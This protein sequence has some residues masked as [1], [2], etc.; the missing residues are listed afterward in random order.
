[1][2]I[3]L[4]ITINAHNLNALIE[5][6]GLT[7]GVG[8]SHHCRDFCNDA[9]LC[10]RMLD[11]WERNK[12][13]SVHGFSIYSLLETEILRCT[14]Y[15]SG[16]NLFNHQIYIN[17]P[18]FIKYFFRYLSLFIL[19]RSL[20]FLYLGS[21]CRQTV[22]IHPS[23]CKRPRQKQWPVQSLFF[24]LLNSFWRYFN[25]FFEKNSKQVSKHKFRRIKCNRGFNNKLLSR[26][27]CNHK[28]CVLWFF[29]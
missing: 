17:Q 24:N 28:F 22:S 11:R 1:M 21:I 3:K 27:I 16:R 2:T 5:G 18:T 7:R 26:C 25:R 9:E 4:N 14:T 19:Y 10:F 8:T 13:S 29:T 6:N 15:F 20:I 12:H 23:V